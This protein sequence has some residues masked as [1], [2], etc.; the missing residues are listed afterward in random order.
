M[1]FFAHQS[2]IWALRGQLALSFAQ[3]GLAK[4]VVLANQIHAVHLS[5][6]LED[7]H[8]SR[9]AH[10]GMGVKTEVPKAAAFVGQSGIDGG[11]IQ[12]ENALVW[13]SGVVFVE[14]IDQRGG[15]RRAITLQDK[16]YPVVNG[17][18]QS[19]QCFLSLAFAVIPGDRKF[20]RTLRQTHAPALVDALD[21]PL[22]VSV[23]GFA[24]IAKRTA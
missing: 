12:E 24:S 14:C 4:T 16:T 15:H 3:D 7:L 18:A 17:V 2:N 9:H 6:F 23:N 1:Q 19:A 11:V 8:Q 21:C 13:L 5:V 22:Q 10:V 20:A